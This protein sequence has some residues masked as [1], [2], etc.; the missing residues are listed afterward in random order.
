M[1]NTMKLEIVSPS[2]V[3]YEGEATMV[4]L[5]GKEGELGVLAGHSSLLALLQSGTIEI[6]YQDGKKDLVAID[7]GYAK[8]NP[9]SISI[10]VNGAVY[11]AG[12]D[13][14]ELKASI[15]KAKDLLTSISS[16]KATLVSTM[17]KI[18]KIKY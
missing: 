6:S 5:P 10:L 18:D 3:I 1:N 7:W 17:S 11:I 2:G 16:D 4:I 9:Q 15:T 8:I 12:S 14:S 13:S